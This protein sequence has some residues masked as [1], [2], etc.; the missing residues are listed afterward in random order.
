MYTVCVCTRHPHPYLTSEHQLRAPFH[1]RMHDHYHGQANLIFNDCR[2]PK[3][4]QLG[5]SGLGFKI[6]MIT[7]DV[8]R[9][10]VAAQA[11]GIGQVRTGSVLGR[12]F[13]YICASEQSPQES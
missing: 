13:A 2:I 1:L 3:S 8:G 6:A 9:I 7:L 11:L 10:G 12:M 5:E 4:N